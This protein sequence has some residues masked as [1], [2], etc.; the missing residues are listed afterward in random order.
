MM[1]L[2][3]PQ[4]TWIQREVQEMEMLRGIN[5]VLQI[6]GTFDDT[7]EGLLT[8]LPGGNTGSE[9]QKGFLQKLHLIFSPSSS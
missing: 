2:G 1:E 4:V 3:K 7:P 9:G 5:N 8:G 6:W